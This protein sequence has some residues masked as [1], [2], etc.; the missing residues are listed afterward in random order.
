[1]AP[2]LQSQFVVVALVRDLRAPLRSRRYGR[3]SVL[4]TASAYVATES[5]APKL[6]GDTLGYPLYGSLWLRQGADIAGVPGLTFVVVAVNACVHAAA[7]SVRAR[8]RRRDACS[9]RC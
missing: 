6:F 3:C 5:F 1:M 4:V 7:A 8:G 2:I 9:R